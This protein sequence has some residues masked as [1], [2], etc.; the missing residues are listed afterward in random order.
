MS[1]DFD[2]ALVEFS[3]LV[4][5][6]GPVTVRGG[7][8]RWDRGGELESGTRELGAPTGIVSYQPDEMTVT[9]RAGTVVSDLHAE[10]ADAGQRT[11]LPVRPGGT[12]GGALSVG[13][14][15]IERLGRGATRDTLLQAVFVAADGQLVTAGGPTVKNVT[16]FD[17]PRLLVGSL[18]TL[19][20]I[21]E[22]ILRTQPMAAREE[23]LRTGDADPAAVLRSTSTADSILW[24]GTST[25]V[26]L[27][28]YPPDVE[29]DVTRLADIGTFGS[30]SPPDLPPHRWS[31]TPSQ[32]LA[33][34]PTETGSFVAEVGVGLVHAERPDRPS[35]RP[36]GVETIETR[37]KA[38]FDPDGRLNP[39]RRPGAG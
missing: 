23:W 24:D 5:P 4:G 25:W 13:E 39:G 12:V 38:L 31:R 32:A 35:P 29:A 36:A 9:V 17:L 15:A 14:S 11:A 21:A 2:A 16:G 3:D 27:A 18:G 10:L 33:L 22:V 8:T 6:G 28:G 37:I 26:L 1:G 7:G 20:L 19:G 30:A 34:D